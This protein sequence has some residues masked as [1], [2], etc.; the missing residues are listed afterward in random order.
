MQAGDV[1]EDIDYKTSDHLFRS[2][3]E[4]AQGKY[5][6]TT[7]WLK[8]RIKPDQLL[9]NI[10]CGSGEYNAAAHAMGLRVAACE[11]EAT[12]F[13]LAANAAPAST[14]SLIHISE[15]TRRTPISY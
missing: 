14:L 5:D 3:D 13:E 15:P 2:K 11:P 9:L 8:S 1:R 12:A 6:V 10:G 4:Y 7:R